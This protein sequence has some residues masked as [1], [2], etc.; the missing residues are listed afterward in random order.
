MTPSN[1]SLNAGEVELLDHAK[2]Q[3]QLLTLVWRGVKI[4]HLPGDHD[5]FANAAAGAIWLAAEAA[6]FSP[7][8]WVRAFA[9]TGAP[10][11]APDVSAARPW[12]K[13]LKQ[14]EAEAAPPAESDLMTIYQRAYDQMST[15]FP[16]EQS[17]KN[18]A[19][20]GA[21]I[22]ASYQTDRIKYWCVGCK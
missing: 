20:C 7:E 2:M 10:E 6:G 16:A 8:L 13:S 3:E 18:C 9:G 1:R 12:R 22:G 19:R 21:A 4:D 5:D 11:T 15:G 14:I 17:K